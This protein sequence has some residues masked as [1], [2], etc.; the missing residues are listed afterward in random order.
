VSQS[1]KEQMIAAAQNTQQVTSTLSEA[2]PSVSAYRALATKLN[3]QQSFTNLF[4][5]QHQFVQ[6][7]NAARL[8]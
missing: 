3:L 7:V 6:Q 1:T 5:A 2:G 4:N 8:G